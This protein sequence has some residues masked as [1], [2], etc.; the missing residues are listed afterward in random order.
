MKTED[1]MCKFTQQTLPTTYYVLDPGLTY[2]C[3]SE[4]KGSFYQRRDSGLVFEWG[5]VLNTPDAFHHSDLNLVTTRILIS[6][7]KYFYPN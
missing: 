3:S 1:V 7:K 2:A 4:Q 5:C 6:F